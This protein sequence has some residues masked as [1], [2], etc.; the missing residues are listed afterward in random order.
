[1]TIICIV[2][3]LSSKSCPASF[4]G[5]AWECDRFEALPDDV[6]GGRA[7]DISI[8]RQSLVTRDKHSLLFLS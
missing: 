6:M 3:L 2:G 1:M 5:S 7:S 4:P 8:T